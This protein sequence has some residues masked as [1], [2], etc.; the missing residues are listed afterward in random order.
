MENLAC[1]NH[2]NSCVSVTDKVHNYKVDFQKNK[3]TKKLTKL[4]LKNVSMALYK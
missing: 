2:Q 4:Q 1:K 3:Q